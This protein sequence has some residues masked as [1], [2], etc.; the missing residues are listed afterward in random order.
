MAA[1]WKITELST[2]NPP[3]GGMWLQPVTMRASA[4]CPAAWAPIAARLPNEI[5][6]DACAIVIFTAKRTPNAE[7]WL[8]RTISFSR[9]R[10]G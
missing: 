6:L 1:S 9:S 7:R 10:S 2:G 4:G 5:R 3:G 8:V